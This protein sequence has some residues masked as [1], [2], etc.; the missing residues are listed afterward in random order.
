MPQAG[1]G[2]SVFGA[3]APLSIR[4]KCQDMEVADLFRNLPAKDGQAV[5]IF[6]S[7]ASIE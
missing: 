4:P 3:Y 5:D 2:A 7:S 6:D 1:K